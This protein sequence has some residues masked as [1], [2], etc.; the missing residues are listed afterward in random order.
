MRLLLDTHSFLWFIT[1]D[2]KL[3]PSADRELRSGGNQLLLSLASVW[4]IAIKV[5][6]GRLPIPTP[7]E[8]F[9]PEQLTRNRIDLLP[10][11]LPHALE[12]A[13]LPLHHRDPFDRLIIAQA[14]LEGLPVVSADGAFD[15]YPIQRLW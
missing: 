10:I 11:A 4:E 13:R 7:L 15:S 12:T 5:G 1:A 3:S 8:Q 14:L 6:I 9:I 2:P